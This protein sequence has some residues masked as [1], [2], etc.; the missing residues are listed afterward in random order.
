[1]LLMLTTLGGCA[2]QTPAPVSDNALPT[3]IVTPGTV[4]PTQAQASPVPGTPSKPAPTATLTHAEIDRQIIQ[5]YHTLLMDEH[6]ADLMTTYIEKTQRGELQLTDGSTRSTYTNAFASPVRA[7]NQTTP[8]QTAALNNGWRWVS[9][10]VYQ[11]LQVYNAL[12]DGQTYAPSSLTG[13]RMLRQYLVNYQSNA[14][15]YLKNM[16]YGAEF[17]TSQHVAVEKHLQNAYGM[18]PRGRAAG[19]VSPTAASASQ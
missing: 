11:Y 1:M 17:V 2:L 9:K 3:T 8:P 14:E 12:G 5:S 13:I 10:V 6:A 4:Q 18:Q 19:T 15:G 7:Y 16:G